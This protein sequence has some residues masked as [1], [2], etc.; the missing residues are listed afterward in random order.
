MHTHTN[1]HTHKGSLI[2]TSCSKMSRWKRLICL[3]IICVCDCV[4]VLT[5]PSLKVDFQS[6]A[7][8]MATLYAF[9]LLS[10]NVRRSKRKKITEREK[11]NECVIIDAGP[12]S[13]VILQTVVCVCLFWPPSGTRRVG[14]AASGRSRWASARVSSR[15]RHS[16]H[17]GRCVSVPPEEP[18]LCC[19]SNSSHSNASGA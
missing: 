9:A 8:T 12:G 1:R 3:L 14:S 15:R 5:S 16:K 10:L 4:C 11:E 19:V 6:R 13:A 7:V 17:P 18:R 2:F